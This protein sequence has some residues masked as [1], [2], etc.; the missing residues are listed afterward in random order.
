[1]FSFSLSFSQDM[2]FRQYSTI[3]IMIQFFHDENNNYLLSKTPEVCYTESSLTK[4]S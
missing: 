4:Q 3:F 1:M 2:F